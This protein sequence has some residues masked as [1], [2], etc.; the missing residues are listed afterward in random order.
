[1]SRQRHVSFAYFLLLSVFCVVPVALAQGTNATLSGTVVDQNGAVV[2]AVEISVV[3]PATSLERTATTNDQ[4]F[5]TVPL[6][7]PGTYTV[8]AKRDG[9][10]GVRIPDVV[11][12]IGDKKSLQIQLK[13]GDINAAVTIQSDAVT[14]N[15]SDGSVSTVVDQKYVANMPL[16]GRSFQSLIL[17]TPGVVTQTPQNSSLAGSGFSKTGEFSVNGQRQESNYFTVDGVSANVGADVGFAPIQ[18]S[19]ASGSLAASTAFGT[20]Q[21]LVSVDALQEFRVQSST[22]SAE[23]GRNPGGQFGFET[24][25]GTNQWHGTA[26]DYFR[27]G[28]LDAN[29]W[30]NDYFGF[31]KTPIQQNDF[32]GTFGGPVILPRF[33]EGGRQPGYNGRNKTFFFFNYEGLR[34]TAPQPAGASFVPDVALRNSTPSPLNQLLNIF[35]V[36]NGLDD[37]VN[38]IAQFIGTWSNP[39]SLNS[40]SVRVDHAVNDRMRLF[41]R[42]SDT[43]SGSV[44]RASSSPGVVSSVPPTMVTTSAYTLRTYTGGVSNG[45]TNRL[46]NEFRINYSSNEVTSRTAFDTFGGGVPVDLR[47]LTGFGSS[48][49]ADLFLIY[50]GYQL[51][52]LQTQASGAQKQWN[53]VDTV[54]LALG[55]HQFKFGVDYRRLAPFAVPA[56][57]VVFYFYQSKSAVQGNSGL[58]N[59]QAF[60]PAYPLYTNFSALLKTNGSCRNG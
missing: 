49:E 28:A 39:N 43:D 56:N 26:Y 37:T 10:S 9:F 14:L 22:Y 29:D 4:G 42:F 38:G 23:Y 51:Q 58:I 15:T 3:N 24:K 40:T 18:S 20:T 50:G 60:A 48:S 1:M 54:S 57:P 52:L 11:L 5:F 31:K 27:N 7:P 33:G 8:T 25:S 30:F 21:A 16:N 46:S 6:L 17:L 47:Q 44:T 45:F 2:P 55:R 19:A 32:G 35:P 41:F 36:P 59:P 13:A 53:L 12:N 34:L